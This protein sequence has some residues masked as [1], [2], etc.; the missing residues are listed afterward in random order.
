EWC[1]EPPPPCPRSTAAC[2][3]RPVPGPDVAQSVR[4]GDQNRNRKSACFGDRGSEDGRIGLMGPKCPTPLLYPAR[5]KCPSFCGKTNAVSIN[6]P[7]FLPRKAFDIFRSHGVGF[8]C[9][10]V[11]A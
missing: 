9:R 7:P 3:T 2:G 5:A 11:H 4:Q 6:F 1:R 8:L 10:R